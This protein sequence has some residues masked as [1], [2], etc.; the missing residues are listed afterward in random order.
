[1]DDLPSRTIIPPHVISRWLDDVDTGRWSWHRNTRCKYVSIKFDTRVGAFRIQDRDGI[2][3][4]IDELLYQY[5]Q[6]QP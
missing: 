2:D 5:G 1:M 6:D 4:T 3:I